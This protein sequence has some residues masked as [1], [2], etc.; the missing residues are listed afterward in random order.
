MNSGGVADVLAKPRMTASGA[1][2]AN[3]RDL[4]RPLSA[5]GASALVAA[6]PILDGAYRK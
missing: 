4:E 1:K 5:S 6:P 2:P 3:S